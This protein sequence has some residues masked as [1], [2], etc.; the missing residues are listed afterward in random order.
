MGTKREL[1]DAEYEAL[2]SFRSAIRQFLHFSSERA[3]EAELNP[4]QHQALLALRAAPGRRLSIGQLGRELLLKPHT[5]SELATRLTR[6]GLVVRAPG[7]DPRERH[8]EITRKG[9]ECLSALSSV[10]RSEV[11]RLR[12]VM[13]EIMRRLGKDEP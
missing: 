4:A 13:A 11:K 3:R 8:L 2:A 6:A 12:P 7:T 1:T 9:E 5:A 10:H